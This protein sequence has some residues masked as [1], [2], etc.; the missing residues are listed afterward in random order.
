MN[1]IVPVMACADATRSFADWQEPFLTEPD[2]RADWYR[3]AL[4]RSLSLALVAHRAEHGLTQTALGRLLGM[5]QAQ[6]SRI[7]GGDHTPSLDTLLR[8]ADTL[9]LA[10]DISVRPRADGRRP[11]PRS[12]KSA[13]VETTD[14]LV[15]E[16]RSAA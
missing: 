10:I 2:V 12:V 3:S 7:E 8:I 11:A 15:I 14:Q 6:V 13:I 5:P 1:V 9:G 16:I 4:A